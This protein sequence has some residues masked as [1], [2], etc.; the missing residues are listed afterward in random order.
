ML[1]VDKGINETMGKT[2]YAS[3]AKSNTYDFNGLLASCMQPRD[4]T[5][6]NNC[7]S[8]GKT[9][10]FVYDNLNR[11]TAV[12][13]NNQEIMNMV[14]AT[15]GNITSKTGVGSYTYNSSV[16]PHAVQSVSNTDGFVEL[17][18]QDITYNLWGKVNP[19]NVHPYSK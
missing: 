8:D 3:M 16:K 1:L 14:Y 5:S 4:L 19:I 6:A 12:E 11:L 10:N 13:E 9:W 17:E 2:G 18:E 15:N 7:M